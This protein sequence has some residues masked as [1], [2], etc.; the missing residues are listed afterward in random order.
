M[1]KTNF[2]AIYL[3]KIIT[4]LCNQKSNARP[5][6]PR[7]ASRFNKR[8]RECC[9]IGVDV[10]DCELGRRYLG[11]RLSVLKMIHHPMIVFKNYRSFRRLKTHP[12]I[13]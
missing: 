11:E 4:L 8:T 5:G 3:T 1:K 9:F 6:V 13:T 7:N 2:V 12:I 10:F